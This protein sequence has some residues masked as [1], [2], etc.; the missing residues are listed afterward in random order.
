MIT[1]RAKGQTSRRFGPLLMFEVLAITESVFVQNDDDVSEDIAEVPTLAS[2]E[3]M[4]GTPDVVRSRA[5]ASRANLLTPST[6]ASGAGG[7]AGAYD[8]RYP[9]G[10]S[11]DGVRAPLPNIRDVLIRGVGPD[12]EE[13]GVMGALQAAMGSRADVA[14]EEK[15]TTDWIFHPPEVGVQRRLGNGLDL[16]KRFH[17]ARCFFPSDWLIAFV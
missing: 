5:H 11:E 9:N 4:L 13:G 2:M 10:F 15:D 16:G 3:E 14:A 7:E 17:V 6:S 1:P 12:Q 8:S